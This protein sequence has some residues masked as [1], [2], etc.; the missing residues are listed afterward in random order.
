MLQLH[1]LCPSTGPVTRF[2]FKEDWLGGI[3]KYAWEKL[4]V[5]TEFRFDLLK[6]RDSL[7]Y[8]GICRM[9]T[10]NWILKK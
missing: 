4:E 10:L 8:L 1:N 2:K 6:V 7:G 3:C 5:H 9:I